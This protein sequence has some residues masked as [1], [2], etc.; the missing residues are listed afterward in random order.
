MRAKVP[1][2]SAFG[3]TNEKASLCTK[4][5][6]FT[7]FLIFVQYCFRI[8]IIGYVSAKYIYI[9][10]IYIYIYN[11][12]SI[13]S[14]HGFGFLPVCSSL[15]KAKRAGRRTVQ[16]GFLSTSYVHF[17]KCTFLSRSK[18]ERQGVWRETENFE[19]ILLPC[20]ITDDVRLLAVIGCQCFLCPPH[21]PKLSG[22]G[23]RKICPP[24]PARSAGSGKA[25]HPKVLTILHK[26]LVG[27]F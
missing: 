9:Y 16:N 3:S 22:C 14:T 24:L 10:I 8:A 11:Y 13:T 27:A 2:L 5:L 20:A 4:L 17:S 18:N 25:I 7:N 23:G 21:P 15:S 6:F 12:I 26:I 19:M 1:H